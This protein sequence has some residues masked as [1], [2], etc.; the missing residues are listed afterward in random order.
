VVPTEPCL[1]NGFLDLQEIR[2]EDI[3]SIYTSF[4]AEVG[5]LGYLH[6]L[7][8]SLAKITYINNR[9]DRWRGCKNTTYLGPDESKDFGDVQV[10][11]IKP[12]SENSMPI[13]AYLVNVDG[14]SIFYSAFVTDS[15]ELYKQSLERLGEY[16]DMIDLAFLPIPEP[17]VE[18]GS[19][20]QIFLDRWNP[21]A[22]CLLDPN[23]RVQLYPALAEQMKQWGYD[24]K[25]FCA[26]NPGDRFVY[27]A[28]SIQ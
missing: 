16:T 26:E 4:H 21:R 25:I 22:V 2:D 12:V 10:Q 3:Y 23:H 6:T 1:A 7:E 8:D 28:S 18:A 5:E 17:G 14:L 9:D 27:S 24:G 20:L 13:L 19:D 15:L 11:A